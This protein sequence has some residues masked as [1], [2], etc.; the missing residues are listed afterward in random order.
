[1][2]KTS[3][4]AA[5]STISGASLMGSRIKMSRAVQLPVQIPSSDADICF[6]R[7]VDLAALVKTKRISVRE[8]VQIHLGQIA[9]INPRVNAIVTL[10]PEDK[11]M[12][13][14][15]AADEALAKGNL[16]GPLHGLPIAVKD[17]TETKGIRTTFGSPI[18]KDFIPSEDALIVDREKKA[19]AIILGKSNVPEL[20][21]GSQTFNPVFGPTFNPYDLTKTCGGSTG[22]GAVAL[23]CGMTPL[24]D[25]SDMGGSLRN[26]PSFCNVVGL[27]P[28]PGRV[29]NILSK[30]GWQDLSVQGP[31]ARTVSDLALLLS[32]QAGADNRCPISIKENP[33]LFAEPLEK[34]FKDVKIAFIKGMGLPWEQEVKEAIGAQVKVFESLGCVV[35]MDEPDMTDANECFV[36]FRHWQVEAGYGDQLASNGDKLNEYT[37]WHIAEA[38]KLTATYLAKLEIKRT[39]LYRRFQK[40]MEKYEFL[41]LPVSQVLPFDVNLH[42]PTEINRTAMQSYIDWMRSAYYV[43]IVGNPALSVP[44]AFS[45]SGLPIG[46]QIVGRHHADFSVL[47][48]GYAFEQATKIGLKR[49]KIAQ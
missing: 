28:S 14:A 21:L 7:A 29:P 44:C 9:R 24:A 4:M 27:R 38:R 22:G 43:S 40:F 13:Q 25:G 5:M 49:P 33:S 23:A 39:A 3:S 36:N 1:M 19:G 15:L 42:Y 35:E 20:G 37:K 8:L 30:L 12:E 26:P 17:L 16:L 45:K 10:V 48:M 18:W 11:L 32:I 34:N 6:S 46:M 2:I 31:V 47:Q 41:V